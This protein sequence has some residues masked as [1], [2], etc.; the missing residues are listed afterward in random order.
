MAAFFTQIQ[1]PGRPKAV[2]LAG[3]RDDSKM[4]LA[5]LREADAIEGLLV[6]SPRFLG[7]QE[8]TPRKNEPYRAALAAWVTSPSNP[9]FA[10]A[11]V[12]RAWWHF[13][14]RGIVNPVDDMHEGNPPSHPEL[15]SELSQ[16]FAESG[17][18][19][20][21]LCR[22]I[23]SSKTYQS[24]SRPSQDPES[25][26]KFFARMS[27]KV[28]TAEQLYDSLVTIFGPPAKVQG[29]D[30]RF[31]PRHEFCQFFAAD[32]EPDPLRYDRGIPHMLRLMNSPQFAGRTLSALVSNAASQSGPPEAVIEQ[33]FLAILS[34][35]PTAPELARF[36]DHLPTSTPPAAAYQQLAW[37]LLMSS[38]FSLNH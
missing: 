24:T 23:V 6:E 9:Y 7:S 22:A 38:E 37:S 25:E 26:G 33:L 15:L 19:W 36:K 12:N 10:R 2:Y 11:M 27:I 1:M 30:T 32:G 35:R 5:S 20:K 14:G 31:G 18:D 13:F 4:T 34:R 21:L 8:F 3:I 17:F 28:L 16:R 29:I